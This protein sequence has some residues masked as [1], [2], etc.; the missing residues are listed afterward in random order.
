VRRLAKLAIQLPPSTL[1]KVTSKTSSIRNIYSCAVLSAAWHRR[2]W[3]NFGNS[4]G[5][6]DNRKGTMEE[7]VM[8]IGLFSIASAAAVC[9]S[10]AAVVL[11][12]TQ[13]DALRG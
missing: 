4:G 3:W 6:D 2:D 12:A 9:L 8:W 1:K 10:V 7:G 5:T 13:G 11:Q